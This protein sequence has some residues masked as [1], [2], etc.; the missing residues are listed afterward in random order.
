MQKKRTKVE[1][2]KWANFFKASLVL[3]FIVL[4]ELAVIQVSMNLTQ[5]RGHGLQFLD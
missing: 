5:L 4:K 3:V 2:E 1:Y